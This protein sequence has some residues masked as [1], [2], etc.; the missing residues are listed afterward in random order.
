MTV[1]ARSISAMNA[2]AVCRAD[3]EAHHLGRNFGDGVRRRGGF[4]SARDDMIRRQHNLYAFARGLG[5]QL[6][7]QVDL[8]VFDP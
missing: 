6:A 2:A 7:R 8:V 3:V 1:L 4:W 5:E